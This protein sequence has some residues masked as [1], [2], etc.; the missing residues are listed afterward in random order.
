EAAVEQCIWRVL[1]AA[2]RTA[3][4]GDAFFVAQDLFGGDGIFL[5]PAASAPAPIRIRTEGLAVRVT[6]EDAFHIFHTSAIDDADADTPPAPLMAIRTQL[7]D[8][9]VFRLARWKC[10]AFRGGGDGGS[11]GGGD[12]GEGDSSA[13]AAWQK[14]DELYERRGRF[15]TICAEMP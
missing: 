2:S 5:K 15:L 4:G 11:G 7:R 9:V 3:S 13:A 10:P 6:T 8:V 14:N 1:H 12:G